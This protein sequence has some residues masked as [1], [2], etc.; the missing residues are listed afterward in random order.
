[1][2]GVII[3]LTV[4]KGIIKASVISGLA[5]F[6]LIMAMLAVLM[7]PLMIPFLLVLLILTGLGIMDYKLVVKPLANAIASVFKWVT[8]KLKEVFKW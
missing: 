5:M 4:M 6:I 3:M 8:G 7:A 1:M 2:K